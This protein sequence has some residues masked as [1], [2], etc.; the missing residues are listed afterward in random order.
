MMIHRLAVTCLKKAATGPSNKQPDRKLCLADSE[1]ECS[2]FIIGLIL[3]YDPMEGTYHAD[4]K[5][6]SRVLIV[7]LEITRG[8]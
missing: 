4:C 7:Q 5:Q 8:A 3:K 1:N 6:E 2:L